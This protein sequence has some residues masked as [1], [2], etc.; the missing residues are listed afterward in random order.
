M[1]RASDMIRANDAASLAEGFVFVLGNNCTLIRISRCC[2]WNSTGSGA[3]EARS[4]F[5]SQVVELEAAQDALALRIMCLGSAPIPDDRE[6]ILL[7]GAGRFDYKSQ[8]C[9]TF[10]RLLADGH[11]NALMSI[12]AAADVA[13]D[14]RDRGSLLVLAQRLVAHQQHRHALLSFARC[15]DA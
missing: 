3:E 13:E 4:L 6:D 14:F 8:S 15:N 9:S 1:S 2:A 10:A 7:T 12:E 5:R 11:Q